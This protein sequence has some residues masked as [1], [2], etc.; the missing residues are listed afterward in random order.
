[1]KLVFRVDC[2]AKTGFGH[3]SR[4]INLCRTWVDYEGLNDFLF[5]GN[6]NQFGKEILSNYALPYVQIKT[7]DFSDLSLG[8]LDDGDVVLIDS[9]LLKQ[10]QLDELVKREGRVILIDDECLLNYVG[11]YAV[12][13]FRFNAE[14]LYN[15]NSKHA[16]LG[17][18]YFIVKP[19]LV[20]LRASKVDFES[21]LS[22]NNILLFFG[23][24]F[25][26]HQFISSIIKHINNKLPEV[27]ILLLGDFKEIRG[28]FTQVRSTP[29]FHKH[30][31]NA[32]ALINAGGLIKYE[33]S[34]SLIPTGSFS[35]SALQYEDSKVLSDFGVHSDFGLIEDGFVLN[36]NANFNAFLDEPS[37]RK[38]LYQNAKT[39]YHN[40]PTLNLVNKL[41][42]IL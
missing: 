1:M 15:Y 35:T 37:V 13:N 11:V 25:N 10:S 22:I 31:V 30:L 40:S 8:E 32:D 27:E 23:G 7:D 20:D 36:K 41:N 24:G 5:I 19:E 4:V 2:N 42:T 18:E 33:A 39:K 9:Y 38:E 26:D 6:Y 16:F 14:K 12:I 29:D 34:F 17:V 21:G 28:E 3:L